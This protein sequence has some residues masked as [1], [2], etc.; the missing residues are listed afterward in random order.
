[1]IDCRFVPIQNWP[2]SRTPKR[3]DSPFDVKYLKLLDDLG[4]ELRHLRAR[5]IVVQA[6]LTLADLRN[7]GWPRSDAKFYDPG[8]VL[9]FR[10]GEGDEIAFPCDTYKSWQGNLR[11]I[12]LTLTALRAIDRYGVTKRKEQYSGWKR[13]AAPNQEMK[14]DAE[15]ALNHL[16]HLANVQPS[17]IRNNANSIDLA[18]RA[19]ARKAHPDSG[20]NTE[21]FQLLQDAVAILKKTLA[22]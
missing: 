2:G 4:R 22:A 1:M 6:H 14:R 19:A 10:A 12:C 7:D 17:A 5:D 9:S 16:A 15:W 20:G 3:K 13:L 21:A 18:Y 11:A 8:I